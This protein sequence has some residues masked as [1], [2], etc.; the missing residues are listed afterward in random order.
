LSKFLKLIQEQE[1]LVMPTKSKCNSK[2]GL[3]SL[4]TGW[5]LSAG[6]GWPPAFRLD[7][8]YTRSSDEC[9]LYTLHA[10]RE[11]NFVDAD[12]SVCSLDWTKTG[13]KKNPFSPYPIWKGYGNKP[14]ALYRQSNRLP[15][16]ISL[17]LGSLMLQKFIKKHGADFL[18]LL[19]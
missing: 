12:S 4:C 7:T 3:A 13:K 17:G 18:P 14:L 6:P 11:R 8:P 15:S 19:Y 16:Y 5:L 9:Q 2:K 1:Q 10:P